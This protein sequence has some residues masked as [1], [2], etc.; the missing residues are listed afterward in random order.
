MHDD[1]RGAKFK[2]TEGLRLGEQDWKRARKWSRP[3]F[4]QE[5]REGGEAGKGRKRKIEIKE[6]KNEECYRKDGEREEK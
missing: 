4:I 3:E 5:K 6:R 2:S 1:G